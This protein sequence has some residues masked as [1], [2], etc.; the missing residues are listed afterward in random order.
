M[1]DLQSGQCN[2]VL[3]G[4]QDAVQSASYA[5]DGTRIV[6]CSFD[7]TARVWNAST[8]VCEG[9]LPH[10]EAPTMSVVSRDASIVVTVAGDGARLWRVEPDLEE[11]SAD[12]DAGQ[13]ACVVEVARL[14]G[15]GAVGG[16][17]ADVAMSPDGALV[18]VCAQD[19][20]VRVYE[21]GRGS[22]VGVFCADVPCRSCAFGGGGAPWV[23]AV[24]TESGQVHFLECVV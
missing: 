20:G 13:H 8:G 11:A 10:Q 16:T 24:G 23:L 14:G 19:G 5:A 3:Q 2:V 6:T 22:A 12:A 1:W 4:H 21:T 18:A 15:V 7:N 17:V 9:I